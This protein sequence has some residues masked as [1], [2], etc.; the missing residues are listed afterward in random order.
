M[1]ILYIFFALAGVMLLVTKRKPCCAECGDKC[2]EDTGDEKSLLDYLNGIMPGFL[3]QRVV[4]EGDTGQAVYPG[5]PGT[6]SL[7]GNDPGVYSDWLKMQE[8]D[9]NPYGPFKPWYQLT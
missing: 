6:L 8:R 5:A 2:T 7:M 4:I 3:K 9:L 1:R